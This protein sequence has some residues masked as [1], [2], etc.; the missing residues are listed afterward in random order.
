[1]CH[2]NCPR[3]RLSISVRPGERA[4]AECPRCRARADLAIPLYETPRPV[5]SS[6]LGPTPAAAGRQP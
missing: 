6:I 1:M 5:R 3:C 2:A 4:R